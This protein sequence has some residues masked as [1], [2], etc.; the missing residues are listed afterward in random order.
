MNENFDVY[1]YLN[2]INEHLGELH[3]TVKYNPFPEDFVLTKELV[4]ER[5]NFSK[6]EPEIPAF[7]YQEKKLLKKNFKN[8]AKNSKKILKNVDFFKKYSENFANLLKLNLILRKDLTNILLTEFRS[9]RFDEVE[10]YKQLFAVNP[11]LAPS[12]DALFFKD[13]DPDSLQNLERDYLISYLDKIKVEEKKEKKQKEK[14][15]KTLPKVKTATKT[16]KKVEKKEENIVKQPSKKTSQTQKP[17]K[18][19]NIK[20]KK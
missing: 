13:F 2:L 20:E 15:E 18:N 19:T 4:K 7:V 17:V 6:I 16:V 3:K 1:N 12:L 9:Y 10:A 11:I 5:L 14:T 8:W